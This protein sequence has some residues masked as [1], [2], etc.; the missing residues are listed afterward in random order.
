[1]WIDTSTITN[2]LCYPFTCVTSLGLYGTLPT[3]PPMKVISLGSSGIAQSN[4]CGTHVTDFL[5]ELEKKGD[6]VEEEKSDDEKPKAKKPAEGEEEED[7][8]EEVEEEEVEEV[9][10]G[11]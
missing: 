1:M 4:T 3:S 2:L 10:P 5:Q 8:D 6:G 7:L 11:K 9:R